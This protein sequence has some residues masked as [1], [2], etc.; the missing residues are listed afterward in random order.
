MQ[1]QKQGPG[2]YQT[3]QQG[4][5]PG[6]RDSGTNRFFRGKGLNCGVFLQS[7]WK[8]VSE[9]MNH[10]AS[11]AD[12]NAPAAAPA[13]A[14]A[15]TPAAAPPRPPAE[16]VWFNLACNAILPGVVL[17]QLSKESR[18]GPA[19][20]L[21]VALSIP[22]GYGIYDLLKR[23]T[24]NVF[25]IIGLVGTLV[26][27]GLGLLKLDNFWF[28]TKAAAIPMVLGLAIPLTL[29]T[30]QPLIKAL[31][32]ND[33]V[34]DTHRIGLALVERN[35]VAGFDALLRWASWVM[36]ATF[37]GSGV[38]NFVLARW[39][40]VAPPG[41]SEQTAQI[42]KLHWIEWPIVTLP[43]MVVMMFALFRLIKGLEALTGLKND[44]LFH[45]AHAQA[46]A[47]SKTDSK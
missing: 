20:G 32:Y 29:K 22:L 1:D 36:A 26:T 14:S 37:I 8:T 6:P 16:N 30:R 2:R 43:M 3:P 42:G 35:T 38:I 23:R 19:W 21:V 11:S 12:P 46:Q 13:P 15:T 33:Q 7:L 10:D 25:S 4:E 39:I 17:T 34:L 28:A 5:H 41:S 47:Q 40:V 27:G 24:W 31:L 18:L 9:R 44:E 45:P